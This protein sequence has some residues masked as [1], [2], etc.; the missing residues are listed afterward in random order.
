MLQTKKKTFFISV[1]VMFLLL[2]LSLHSIENNLQIYDFF[3]SLLFLLLARIN[4]IGAHSEMM[5][6]KLREW[7]AKSR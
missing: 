5:E 2:P 4:F 1:L 6:L 7:I 3:P